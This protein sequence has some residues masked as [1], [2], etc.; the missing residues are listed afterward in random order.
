MTDELKPLS[1]SGFKK[2]FSELQDEIDTIDIYLVIHD[3]EFDPDEITKET[4]L[5]PYRIYK[6]GFEYIRGKQKY[7][8]DNNMW[9]IKYSHKNVIY[10]EEA[11]NGF[12]EN[13]IK[14]NK[15]YFKKILNTADGR[16]EFVYNYFKTNNMGIV[17]DREF[18]KLLSELNLMVDFDLYCLHEDE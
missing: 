18:V 12:I 10:S 7:I 8:S 2:M 14:P 16:I 9:E 4:R 1:K 6:K 13:I 17:F 5:E 11:I 15:E 3:I